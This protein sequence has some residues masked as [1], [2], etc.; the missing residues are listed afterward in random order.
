MH[1]LVTESE[2]PRIAGTC[3]QWL[4]SKSALEQSGRIA[5]MRSSDDANVGRDKV[6]LILGIEVSNKQSGRRS[7]NALPRLGSMEN[8]ACR[9]QRLILHY[10]TR[11][12][13]TG[14]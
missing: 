8:N 12:P 6:I 14:A 4:K 2:G 11:T 3:D 7:L 13:R 5:T 10:V 9:N 1:R